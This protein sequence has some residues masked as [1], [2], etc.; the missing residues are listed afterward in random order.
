[1][2]EWGIAGNGIADRA[3]DCVGAAFIGHKLRNTGERVRLLGG[4]LHIAGS[5]SGR[6]AAID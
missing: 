6:H 5:A 2:L 3:E 1:M 4:E